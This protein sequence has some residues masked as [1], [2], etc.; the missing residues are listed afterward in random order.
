[1]EKI[2]TVKQMIDLWPMRSVMADDLR[3]LGLREINVGRVHKWAANNAIPAKYHNGVLLAA[4]ARGFSVT[5][6][7]LVSIHAPQAKGNAA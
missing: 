2:S 6:D 1:M 5:A 3:A 4:K 7:L